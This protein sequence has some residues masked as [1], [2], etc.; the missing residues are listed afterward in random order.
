MIQ[1]D[2]DKIT[3]LLR[4]VIFTILLILALKIL[5]LNEIDYRNTILINIICFMFIEIYFPFV[6]I[7]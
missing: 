5:S 6:K 4:L 2:D 3:K 7:I 1:I